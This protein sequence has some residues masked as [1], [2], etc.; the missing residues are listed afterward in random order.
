MGVFDGPTVHSKAI[1]GPKRGDAGDAK[2][3]PRG[4]Q[5]GSRS[6]WGRDAVMGLR[7]RI[8]MERALR[9]KALNP[10]GVFAGFILFYREFSDL[11]RRGTT[12]VLLR[13]VYADRFRVPPTIAFR[14]SALERMTLVE[15]AL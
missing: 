3:K 9:A 15:V 8:V 1:D 4:R 10:G 5:L 2:K 14:T 11:Y 6:P 13:H 7:S 12:P